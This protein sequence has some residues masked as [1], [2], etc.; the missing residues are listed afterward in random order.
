MKGEAEIISDV[1]PQQFEFAVSDPIC[2]GE[3]NGNLTLRG[4]ED[5]RSIQYVLQRLS[6]AGEWHDYGRALS[7]TGQALFW[8]NMIAGIYRVEAYSTTSG[9]RLQ[10]GRADTLVERPYPQVFDLIARGGDTTNCEGVDPDVVLE[11]DGGEEHCS[12]T[13]WRDGESTGRTLTALPCVWDKVAG[14]VSGSVYSVEAV[15]QYG[16]RTEMGEVIVVEKRAPI[17]LLVSGGGVLL[18]R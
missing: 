14:T 1:T 6:D 9:C 18:Y 15:S 11:L 8:N 12:Y 3:T 4:S 2:V 5:D 17:A 7:G 13:L 10:M 16:C